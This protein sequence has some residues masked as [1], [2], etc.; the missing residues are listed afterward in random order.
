[1]NKTDNYLDKH[2]SPFFLIF[3]KFGGL[4]YTIT[5]FII[6][7]IVTLFIL[8]SINKIKLFVHA[9]PL[10]TLISIYLPGSIRT[11]YLIVFVLFLSLLAHK[12]YNHE[13]LLV[14]TL[15]IYLAIFAFYPI[16]PT[17]I[18]SLSNSSFE[19]LTVASLTMSQFWIR[20]LVII[21]IAHNITYN[22]KLFIKF[23]KLFYFVSIG[24]LL[25]GIS[26][27]L[28]IVPDI[29]HKITFLFIK[30]SNYF[31]YEHMVNLDIHRATSI[32]SHPTTFGYFAFFIFMVTITNSKNILKNIS[33]K[34]VIMV[35]LLAG[36]ASISKVF[37]AGILFFIIYEI[38]YKRKKYTLFL[39][40]IF[41]IFIFILYVYFYGA[42]HKITLFN[43]LYYNVDLLYTSGVF[44][45]AF[46]TRYDSD[47]GLLVTTIPY[48]IDNFIF[49]IGANIIP[50][51]FYGDSFYF[52]SLLK[53]GIVG[54]V[55]FIFIILKIRQELKNILI[56]VD[57]QLIASII[58]TL[59][60]LLLFNFIIAIGSEPFV[61]SRI[62]EI[63]YFM[64]F[65][66]LGGYKT[67]EYI[68]D[69]KKKTL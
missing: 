51:I 9:M 40:L 42:G 25:H 11:D 38:F 5:N 19:T 35:C 14:N 18:F 33:R 22:E 34:I 62:T 6:A 27:T 57:S 61:L 3:Y 64:I 20:I 37:F 60:F 21:F 7:S 50:G 45:Y 65:L 66:F 53:Y 1:M 17:F 10:F 68:S 63:F 30:P 28:G 41:F 55:F 47:T 8:L 31:M 39:S 48:I 44:E 13:K 2:R 26:E 54:T 58:Q 24:I 15:F 23:F 52:S 67:R 59:I 36:L 32:L 56:Y 16:L 4:I 43:T 12:F 29:I 49:G 69:N 46:R